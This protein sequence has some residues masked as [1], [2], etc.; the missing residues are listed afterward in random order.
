M[1]LL[2][3]WIQPCLKLSNV[4]GNVLSHAVSVA[5]LLERKALRTG[6]S[7]RG[8][9]GGG[10]CGSTGPRTCSL[11]L[12]GHLCSCSREALLRPSRSSERP[13]VPL[14]MFPSSAEAFSGPDTKLRNSR[15]HWKDRETNQITT[16]SCRLP[17]SVR[18]QGQVE[19]C[20]PR[21]SRALG[22]DPRR[23][24][25]AASPRRLELTSSPTASDA[26]A[27]AGLGAARRYRGPGC[28]RGR[29]SSHRCRKLEAPRS[30]RETCRKCPI[31]RQPARSKQARGSAALWPGLH[32]QRVCDGQRESSRRGFR[33]RPAALRDPGQGVPP[34]G[35]S[36]T[37][38]K[39]GHRT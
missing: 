15:G 22:A 18:G 31:T 13:H 32:G 23:P 19:T 35:L 28:P 11:G 37:D 34:S 39:G 36:F 38:C 1:T 7:G 12:R 14:S 33:A 8:S 27:R 2:G 26:G 29:P 20:G 4:Q 16:H 30:R 17:P 10:A 25:R 6:A 9:G 24:G 21:G 5:C 3:S